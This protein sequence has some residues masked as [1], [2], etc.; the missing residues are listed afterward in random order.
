MF[1]HRQLPP[2][3]RY[4]TNTHNEHKKELLPKSRQDGHE[5]HK[6]TEDDGP[7]TQ[8]KKRVRSSVRI[9]FGL[10]KHTIGMEYKHAVFGSC[11]R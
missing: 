2:I 9:F 5:A 4:V 8:K 11:Y 1:V 6:T 7:Y 3:V 10:K